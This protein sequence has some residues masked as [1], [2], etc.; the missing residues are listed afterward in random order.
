MLDKNKDQWVSWEC[1]NCNKEITSEVIKGEEVVNEKRYD[2]DGN[3]TYLHTSSKGTF[4]HFHLCEECRKTRMVCYIKRG[5][6]MTRRETR[7]LLLFEILKGTYY[8]GLMGFLIWLLIDTFKDKEKRPD[9]TSWIFIG[10]A[11]VLQILAYIWK[12]RIKRIEKET[13]EILCDCD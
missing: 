6:K 2:N 11:I 9:K 1:G 13:K 8:L 3:L 10:L 5:R 7:E 12:S 4:K